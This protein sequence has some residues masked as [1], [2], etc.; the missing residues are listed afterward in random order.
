MHGADGLRI[1]DGISS[2]AD[3]KGLPEAAV[4]QLIGEVRQ[5]ILDVTLKNGGHLASSLG[6]AEII[7]ALLRVFDPSEDRI[8]FDVGHQ[9]YA[10][11]ILTGRGA[12]FGTLRTEGGVSGFPKM[13][14]S[15][16]DHFGVGHSST[17]LSAALGYAAARDLK[18]EKHNVVAVIGDGALINGLAFEALNQ[19][20]TLKTPLI[21]ILN[22]NEMSISPRVGGIAM[23][24]AGLS[25]SRVYRTAKNAVKSIAKHFDGAYEFLERSK[26]AA[27]KL[28]MDGNLFVEMGLTYW[29]PFDGHD[30]KKLEKVFSLAKNYGSPLLIHVVTKKGKGYAPAENDPVAYHGVPPAGARKGGASWS[31]EAA[32]CMEALAENDPRVVVLTP[33]MTVGSS[34]TGFSKKF[35]DRFFDVGIAE[36]HMLT[37]SAGL[38]AGGMHPIACIY[39][40]FLQR[41]ADQLVHDICI[42]KLPVVLAIDRAGLVGEDGE[43]HQGLFDLNWFSAVPNISVWSPFDAVSL[44]AAFG[45]ASSFAAP[46]A[47]RYPRGKAPEDVL[48]DG[49]ERSAQYAF[50]RGNG[51]DCIISFGAACEIALR[52][53]EI[54]RGKGVPVPDMIFPNR[55]SPLPDGF[56]DLLREYRRVCVVEE[57]YRKGGLF[58]RLAGFCAQNGLACAL[59]SFAVGS[60]FVAQGTVEQQR[61]RFGLTPER[62]AEEYVR[63]SR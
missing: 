2:P 21:F 15:P 63:E 40:T 8:I 55:V 7:T 3:V 57:N 28:V 48:P 34:L 5:R 56:A 14:E 38:A 32:A 31:G 11:K 41:A 44:R 39:S 29:G 54:L 42:Q 45:E 53:S 62:I 6:A 19:A 13:H 4:P 22:D 9:A 25:A 18:G 24:L 27:K 23:H 30:E 51:E 10:W 33:A 1:L 12:D 61:R 49:A 17:S 52:A 47:I 36:E 58:E 35:P 60:E 43:T 37:F 46:I 26:N 16:Y 20:G 59:R 50:V